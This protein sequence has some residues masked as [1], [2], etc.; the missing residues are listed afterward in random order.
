MAKMLCLFLLSVCSRRNFVEKELYQYTRQLLGPFV[1][2]NRIYLLLR[3]SSYV[4][5]LFI[6]LYTPNVNYS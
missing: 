5:R 6:N 1:V 4:F 3:T 2:S